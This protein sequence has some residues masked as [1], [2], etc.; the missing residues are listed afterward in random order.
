MLRVPKKVTLIL[1][2]GEVIFGIDLVGTF[3]SNFT[4]YDYAVTSLKGLKA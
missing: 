3:R 2:K 4:H 1:M